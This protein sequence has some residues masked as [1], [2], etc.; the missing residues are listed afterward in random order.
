[1]EEVVVTWAYSVERLIIKG[2]DNQTQVYKYACLI[3]KSLDTQVQKLHN[4]INQYPRKSLI[5]YLSRSSGIIVLSLFCGGCSHG[6][7]NKSVNKEDDRSS[8]CHLTTQIKHN[9]KGLTFVGQDVVD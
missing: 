3:V 2:L 6:C 9:R 7:P 1:M 8:Q 5:S 4:Q